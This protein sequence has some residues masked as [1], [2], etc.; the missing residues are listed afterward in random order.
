MSIDYSMSIVCDISSNTS[1]D[2]NNLVASYFNTNTTISEHEVEKQRDK[3]LQEHSKASDIIVGIDLGTTNSC[4]AIWR[5]NNLEVI[6][7]KYG[8]RTIP[9]IVGFTAK[10]KY[11]SY[12]AKNQKILNPKNVYFEVKRLIGKY[13]TD[14]SVINERELLSYDISGTVNNNIILLS[15]YNKVYTPEEI[16][17]MILIELKNMAS[18]YLKTN[19]K[20][21]VITVP[22]YFNDAQRQAT[23]DAATIAGLETIRIINEPTAAALAYGMTDRSIYKKTKDNSGNVKQKSSTVLVYDLGGGT[24]DCTIMTITDGIFQV[25]GSSGNTALGGADFD[26]KLIQYCID[27]FNKKHK[28]SANISPLSLQKLKRVCENTKI[29]LSTVVR[30]TIAVKDFYTTVDASNNNK[31]FDLSI[32]MTRDRFNDICRPLTTLCLKCIDDVLTVSKK[33]RDDIDEIILVGGMTRTPI[34]RD[35]IKTYFNKDPNCS[36]NPDEAVAAGAAIQAFI[37]SNSDDPFSENVTLLD[38]V[39]LSLGVQVSGGI[40]D[41]IINRGTYMPVTKIKRYTND[42]DNVDSILIK[43]FEGERDIT[44]DNFLVGEFELKGLD[45]VSKGRMNIEVKFHIDING[46]I[47]VSARET[48]SDVRREMIITGNKGRLTTNEINK[49][50][51]EA[52]QYNLKDKIERHK[53]LLYNNVADL[54]DNVKTNLKDYKISDKDKTVI[55]NDINDIL[56][57]L[58][59]KQYVERDESDYIQITKSLESKYGTLILCGNM[60]NDNVKNAVDAK[61]SSKCTTVYGDEDEEDD[62]KVSFEKIENDDMGIGNL[63]DNEKK[64]IKQ[65]RESLVTLCNSIHDMSVSDELKIPDTDKR[66]MLDYIEDTLLWIYSHHKPSRDEYTKRIN[67]INKYCNSIADD[68]KDIFTINNNKCDELENMCLFI[69]ASIKNNNYNGVGIDDKLLSLECEVDKC[70][71]W[72]LDNT[73]KSNDVVTNKISEITDLCNSLFNFINGVKITNN[74]IID[75]GN[76]SSIDSLK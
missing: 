57:W 67:D 62:V 60:L 46:I 51:T 58:S 50:I 27:F 26:N 37:L 25:L 29:L 38:V 23:K 14:K 34:I 68:Y 71:V 47:T 72:L 36:I 6:P 4:V 40:M 43:V 56:K 8:N 76:G 16:S 49:L 66:E 22:A 69:K 5:N 30:T 11:I 63:E 10:N 75:S 13:I 35:R 28:L 7:D 55:S 12:D 61:D 21:A 9:S 53:R 44:R 1:D 73:A 19:I 59:S 20:K 24:V 2:I 41:K 33:K 45:K 32:D 52:N 17:A 3:T 48:I 42:T 70:L 15:E 31:T 39:S 74:S 64:D 54:C 18:D 65:L